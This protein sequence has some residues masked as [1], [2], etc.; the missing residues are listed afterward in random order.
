MLTRPV[1]IGSFTCGHGQ[2]LLVIA[3][4]C[5]IEDRNMV[6]DLAA[7]LKERT[8]ALGLSYVFK[9]S[10]DKGNRTG[11]NSF[12]GPGLEKG[13]AILEAVRKEVG[14]PVTSDVHSVDEVEAASKVLDIIQIPAL[15][16]R[17]TDLIQAAARTGKVINVKKGQFLAPLDMEHVIEKIT[18]TGNE[19]VL[20]TERGSS[21][22][23]N[24]LVVDMRSLPLMRA[25]GYPVIFDASHSVQLPGAGKGRSAGQREL[26]EPLARAAVA[27]GVDGVFMEVHPDPDQAL[28]D[29]PN[30][31]STKRF[32]MLLGILKEIDNVVKKEEEEALR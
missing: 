26:A 31:L 23:Y 16:S 13:L 4:P 18:S 19:K 28:C 30:M 14:V 27:A 7:F 17:Q 12:R 10:Y 24:N 1:P 22:G 2:P 29:G 8:K 20:I 5:V 11:V 25:F 21:F 9:A 15:L 6:L 32:S 3:G